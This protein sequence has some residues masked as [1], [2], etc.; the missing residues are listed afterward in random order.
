M[1]SASMIYGFIFVWKATAHKHSVGVSM[2]AIDIDH[3]I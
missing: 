1:T 2:G 3:P